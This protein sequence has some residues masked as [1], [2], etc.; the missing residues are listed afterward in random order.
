MTKING[1]F[2][3]LQSSRKLG[4]SLSVGWKL[5]MSECA[6][7]S[8]SSGPSASSRESAS[9]TETMVLWSSKAAPLAIQQLC[10]VPS[11]ALRVKVLHQDLFYSSS[12]KIRI[13]VTNWSIS[14]FVWLL[15]HSVQ[16]FWLNS[17]TILRYMICDA[18]Y[19]EIKQIMVHSFP[20][21]FSSAG[22]IWLC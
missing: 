16:S 11:Q 15:T 5:A 13:G 19:I 2:T 18:T 12:S 17:P 14:I 1:A 10:L 20:V 3:L 7:S 21:I 22:L 4:T 6:S 9:S 8:G